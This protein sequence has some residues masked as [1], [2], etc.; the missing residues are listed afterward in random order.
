MDAVSTDIETLEFGDSS[1]SLICAAIYARVKRVNGS[2]SCQL[3]FSR[4]KV[5]PEGTSM[6]RGGLSV[7]HLYAMTGFVVRRSFG[8]YHKGYHQ[9]T[10]SQVALYWIHSRDKLLKQWV[11][12]RVRD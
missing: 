2:Y 1:N 4:S 9:F 12:S 6:P 5:L 7:A 8:D 3:V 10:D 11:W